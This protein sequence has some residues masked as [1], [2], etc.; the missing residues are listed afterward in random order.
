MQ[1]WGSTL[2]GRPFVP[3]DAPE[4]GQAADDEAAQVRAALI[5]DIDPA[6]PD[7]EPLD[8]GQQARRLLGNL[9]GWHRREARTEWFEWYRL[10]A[11]DRDGLRRE[12]A[13]IGVSAY[14]GVVG[15]DGRSDVHRWRFD[16][17]Q[18]VKLHHG[19]KVVAVHPSTPLTPVT[20]ARSSASISRRVFSS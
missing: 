7:T 6:V 12:N 8:E 18:E 5:A 10:R 3:G 2:G 1:R 19:D 14:D 17:A 16:P 20:S 11:L 4:D 15:R 9:V 13:T